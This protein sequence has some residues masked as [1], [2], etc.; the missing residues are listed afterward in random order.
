MRQGLVAWLFIGG[1]SGWLAGVLINGAGF[2]LIA[3]I[4]IGII[5]AIIGG[6][7]SEVVGLGGDHGF[8]S[9]LLTA[10]VGSIIL[11]FGISLLKRF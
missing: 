6:W 8:V 1:V 10:I 4:G 11:L 7:L 5:G 2:G 9:S 3:D